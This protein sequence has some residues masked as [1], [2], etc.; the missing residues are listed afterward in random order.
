M[1]MQLILTRT[2]E[3]LHKTNSTVF[4]S[5]HDMGIFYQHSTLAYLWMR[6]NRKEKCPSVALALPCL[7]FHHFQC[8]WLGSNTNEKEY[9]QAPWLSGIWNKFQFEQKHGLLGCQHLHLLSW[10]CN[11]CLFGV[12]LR[13]HLNSV[14][15]ERWQHPMQTG[16]EGTV[17]VF[18]VRI[19]SAHVRA[20]W[21]CQTSFRKHKFKDKI[22][23]TFMIPADYHTISVYKKG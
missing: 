21:S 19:F 14:S 4:I 22:I 2:L 20:P 8:E 3:K 13:V 17:D 11:T 6:K 9:D 16:C 23:D 7:W 1:Q 12:L 5:L 15:M 18:V 10:G